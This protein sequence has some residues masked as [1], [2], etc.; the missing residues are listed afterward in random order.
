[1]KQINEQSKGITIA[2]GVCVFILLLGVLVYFLP[3]VHERLS[4]R[5]ANLRTQIKYAL[6]PPEEAIFV[7]EE[8][9]A[10]IVQATFE[11]MTPSPTPDLSTATPPEAASSPMPSATP[12]VTPTPLPQSVVLTG[13]KYEHQH[14]RWNYCGPANLSMSLTFW[15]WDGNRDVVGQAVKPNDKDKNVMPTRCR[16]SW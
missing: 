2:V 3:P 13:V 8:Q 5:V 12:T 16:T 4:W 6:N 7:P 14:N 15:G 11:A 1:M 9:I 10:A